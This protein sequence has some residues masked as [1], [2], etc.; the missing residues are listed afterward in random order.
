MVHPVYLYYSTINDF[1]V[2]KFLSIEVEEEVE[3]EKGRTGSDKSEHREHATFVLVL[4]NY[5]ARRDL[6]IFNQIIEIFQKE[7][8]YL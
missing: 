4:L 8:W 6:I 2:Q 5:V 1:L 7:G 3:V